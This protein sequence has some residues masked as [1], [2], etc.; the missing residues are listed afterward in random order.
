MKQLTTP[1]LLLFM[2]SEI[3]VIALRNSIS[4]SNLSPNQS[5]SSCSTSS[6]TGNNTSH[7][8]HDV[9]QNYLIGEGPSH[10][11]NNEDLS[12]DGRKSNGINVPYKVTIVALRAFY[13]EHSHL[14]LPRRYLCPA[15]PSYPVAWHGID[16]AGTVY[17]YSWWLTH[18]KEQPNRVTEL[19]KLGFCWERLQP[20][21]NL[22]F[23]SLIVYKTLYGDVLVPYNFTV[24]YNDGRWPKACWGVHLG[25]SV[26]KIRNR[27]DFI[28]A[29]NPNAF[30][31][32]NQLDSIGF[33][34]D[35]QEM[36]FIKL[37]NALQLFGR[38]E[39]NNKVHSGALKVPSQYVVPQNDSRWPTEFWGYRLGERCS[40]IRQKEL[41]I[42]GHPH[43]T[44]MLADV[45][46]YVNGGSNNNLRWLEVVHAAAIYSQMNNNSLDVPTQFIVPAPPCRVPNS[47]VTTNDLIDG[48]YS[49]FV[50]SN[51]AWPWPEYL[52]A[53]PLGQRLRDIR[54]KGNYLKG[55][56]SKARR[57]Q[58]DALNF[59]W[60]PKRG[61]RKS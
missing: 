55:K 37:Y 50:G 9:E 49:K 42:K 26:Q 31:R 15:L 29:N 10:Q 20:E 1:L 38:I 30:S 3:I 13:E 11:I 56:N 7:N 39:Q 46:F 21:W 27:G 35:V 6:K 14:A 17:S 12:L 57:Q 51:D 28:G 25:N 4:F 43:R 47:S 45:G 60:N 8:V 53:F 36:R 58:L 19:N 2:S 52:W 32:R 22:I 5:T 44:N 41:Y 16:L 18:V 34:W 40:Q 24:P 61:A 54:V 59:N 23:E 48:S 33:V